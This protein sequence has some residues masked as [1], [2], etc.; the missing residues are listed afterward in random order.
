MS[1]QKPISIRLSPEI[2]AI[3]DR[4]GMPRKDYITQAVLF[5]NS[6]DGALNRIEEIID[7]KLEEKLKDISIKTVDSTE[8]QCNHS[9][10]NEYIM[11][12]IDDLLEI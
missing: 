7:K 1:K 3:I 12:S 5:K 10:G 9:K 2:L 8:S 6:I 11:S 4:S